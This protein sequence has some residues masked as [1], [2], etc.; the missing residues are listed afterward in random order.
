MNWSLIH[1]TE[2]GKLRDLT[3]SSTSFADLLRKIG[4]S[5]YSSNHYVALRKRLSELGIV[6]SHFSQGIV[7]SKRRKRMTLTE[8]NGSIFIENS[9][10]HQRTV[11]KYVKSYS[12]IPY[13]CSSCS[14][15]GDWNGCPLVLQLDHINGKNKDNRISNLRWLCPNCHSQTA[16]WGV[17]NVSS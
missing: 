3:A 16:T 9:E 6:C 14:H 15:K 10:V 13:V 8:A 17:K 7:L 12:L 5:S 2:E 11:R 1:K 4:Y